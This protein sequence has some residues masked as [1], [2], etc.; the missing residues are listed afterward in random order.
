MTA[1]MNTCRRAWSSWSMT[2]RRFAKSRRLEVTTIELVALSAL[3]LTFDSK[4][5]RGAL[6]SRLAAGPRRRWPPRRR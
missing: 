1:S 3:T 2:L 6:P 5:S 4:I